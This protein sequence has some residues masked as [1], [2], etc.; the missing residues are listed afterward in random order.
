[1]KGYNMNKVQEI[2][3][4]GERISPTDVI[5]NELHYLLSS[6]DKNNIDLLNDIQSHLNDA[7]E[8]INDLKIDIDCELLENASEEIDIIENNIDEKYDLVNR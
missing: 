5:L 2:E 3:L 8:L 4:V 7:K 1:M 6:A